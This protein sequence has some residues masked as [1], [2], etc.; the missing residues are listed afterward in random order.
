M[1]YDAGIKDKMRRGIKRDYSSTARFYAN[2]LVNFE[3]GKTN[4]E[5]MIGVEQLERIYYW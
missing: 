5:L 3:F 2:I 4:H 1:L